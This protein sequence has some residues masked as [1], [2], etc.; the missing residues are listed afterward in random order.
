MD[1]KLTKAHVKQ[2]EQKLLE[3]EAKDA[4]EEKEQPAT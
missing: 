4:E 3:A 1:N 2:Q